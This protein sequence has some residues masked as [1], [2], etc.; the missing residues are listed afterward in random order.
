MIFCHKF[1][2]NF[3]YTKPNKKS[4][5]ICPKPKKLYKLYKL[6]NAKQTNLKEHRKKFKNQN[7]KVLNYKY[8]LTERKYFNI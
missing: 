8:L 1:Y 4:P 2:Y 6:Y 3:N 5:D 7:L